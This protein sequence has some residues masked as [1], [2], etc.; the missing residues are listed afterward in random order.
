MEIDVQYIWR[1]NAMVSSSVVFVF[2]HESA[3]YGINLGIFHCYW[4]LWCP[5]VSIHIRNLSLLW[6]KHN[7]VATDQNQSSSRQLC[8]QSLVA[9]TMSRIYL[10]HS[11]CDTCSLFSKEKKKQKAILFNIYKYIQHTYKILVLMLFYSLQLPWLS[12]GIIEYASIKSTCRLQEQDNN[13]Q[14]SSL[15]S[16]NNNIPIGSAGS[17]A[18][19]SPPFVCCICE[20]FIWNRR[21]LWLCQHIRIYM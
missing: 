20:Y 6:T 10:P 3:I 11:H 17:T 18:I 16:Y 4:F 14:I 5:A 9:G 15:I 19:V 2:G 21:E 7:L 8:Q 12:I 1:E 13:E